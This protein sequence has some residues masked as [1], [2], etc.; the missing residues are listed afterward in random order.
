MFS[1][2]YERMLIISSLP[3][4]VNSGKQVRKEFYHA[5]FSDLIGNL[6]LVQVLPATYCDCAI[7]LTK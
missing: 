1:S 7:L 3:A 4:G 2:T 5:A 6:F